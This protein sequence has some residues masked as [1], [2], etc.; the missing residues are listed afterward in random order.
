MDNLPLELKLKVM[1]E[2]LKL[3]Y[4][5]P[6]DSRRLAPLRQVSK[7]WR[8]AFTVFPTRTWFYYRGLDHCLHMCKIIRGMTSLSISFS[9]RKCPNQV[10][11]SPVAVCSSLRNISLYGRYSDSDDPSET[12]VD[13]RQIPSG[14]ETMTLR[15]L[16]LSSPDVTRLTRLSSL[17]FTGKAKDKLSDETWDVLQHLLQLKVDYSGCVSKQMIQGLCLEFSQSYNNGPLHPLHML[18]LQI[19]LPTLLHKVSTLNIL[20]AIQGGMNI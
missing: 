5:C 15:S 14:I 17:T 12:Y 10:D 16:G 6:D 8:E 20:I 19:I 18:Q 13:M 4:D 11:F 3:E 9:T 7:S 2:L 1:A